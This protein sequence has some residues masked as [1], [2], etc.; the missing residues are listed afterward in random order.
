MKKRLKWL[1]HVVRMKDNRLP[2]I[3]LFGQPSRA[4]RK[5]GRLR[6]GWEDVIKKDLMEMGTSWVGVIREALNRLGGGEA[7]VAVLASG[8]L[9]LRWIVSSSSS[10]RL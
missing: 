4:K 6:L 7:C 9:L 1:G 10:I 2:K 8:D 5:V 3:V